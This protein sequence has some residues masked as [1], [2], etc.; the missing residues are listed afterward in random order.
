MAVTLYQ[1]LQMEGIRM[2]NVNYGEA[3]LQCPVCGKNKM[4]GT[5]CSLNLKKDVFHCFH[6]NT[7]GGAAFVYS[8]IHGVPM[9]DAKKALKAMDFDPS[10]G[11]VVISN[12]PDEPVFEEQDTELASIEVR[13][14][15]YSKLLTILKLD[16]KHQKDL[17]ARGLDSNDLPL[18]A[19]INMVDYS[20]R[21]R[22]A[23]VLIKQ[24]AVLKGVPG[25]FKDREGY[26]VIMKVKRGIL[27]PYRDEHGLIQGLQ[28][29][30]DKESMPKAKDG[31]VIGS[32]Y[33]WLS[34]KRVPKGCSAGTGAKTFLHYAVTFSQDD[35]GVN[36]PFF[37]YDYIILTEGGMKADIF[38]RLSGKPA[39]AVPGV[40]AGRALRKE[41]RYLKSKQ[42]RTVYLEFDMDYEQNESVASAMEKVK[43]IIESEGLICKRLDWDT[44][45][46]KLKG[47]DDFY[48]YIKKGIIPGGK[49]NTQAEICRKGA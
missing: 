12:E 7:G 38:N 41:L 24:G 46:G 6:C 43:H 1:L 26:W 45:G 9:A 10:S 16:Q 13:N 22:I 39:L 20:E 37:P 4:L 15:T 3:S 11:Q 28:I 33:T 25:F 5:S 36:E 34:S 14:D 23:S 21:R 19:T 47:I 27:V 29:R 8:Q 2:K 17:V 32:K 49:N 30:K 18:Y 40:N 48:A 42:I 31:S 44:K 35:N